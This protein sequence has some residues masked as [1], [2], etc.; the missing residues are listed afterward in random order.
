MSACSK[1]MVLPGDYNLQL[2]PEKQ[3]SAKID[4]IKVT[5]IVPRNINSKGDLDG[6]FL[7][8]SRWGSDTKNEKIISSFGNGQM[9]VERRVDNGVAGS[10]LIYSIK[11]ESDIKGNNKIIALTPYHVKPYQDGLI[12]PFPVPKFN[13]EKYLSS[14]SVLH[15]FE[16][17]SEFNE[18]SIKAN[19]ERL[20]SSYGSGYKIKIGDYFAKLNIK[21]YPYR[22]GSK[23]MVESNISDMKESQG[24]INVDNYIKSLESRVKNVVN[25]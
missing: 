23:V 19:F 6:L 8:S 16:V 11:V 25:D 5:Y 18:T 14:A 24:V 12:L 15:K 10:G 13:L 22:N 9:Q 20:L 1:K 4:N 7:S 17:I 3:V 2:V 21:I